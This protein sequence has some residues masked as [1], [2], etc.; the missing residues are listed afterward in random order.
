MAPFPFPCQKCKQGG[1]SLILTVR[2]CSKSWRLNS[3]KCGNQPVTGSPLKSVTLRL[4]Y[5]EPPAIFPLYFRFPYTKE[6]SYAPTFICG[7]SLCWPVSPVWG[8]N[9][10][11]NHTSLPDL[12][13][14]VD[15]STFHLLG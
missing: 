2:V 14:V 8:S 13:R 15:F 12:R 7:D 10:P 1:F 4:V 11:C 5:P 6:W 9:L 3:P